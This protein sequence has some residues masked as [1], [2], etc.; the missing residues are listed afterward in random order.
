MCPAGVRGPRGPFLAIKWGN[1]FVSIACELGEV[2]IADENTQARVHV[3]AAT[4][5]FAKPYLKQN[6]NGW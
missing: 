5:S 6:S 1:V 4:V 2:P 3:N